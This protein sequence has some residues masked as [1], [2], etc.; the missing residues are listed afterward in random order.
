MTTNQEV[1]ERSRQKLP[2]GV[3]SP[4]RAF[5]SVGGTPPVIRQ[6]KGSRITDVEGRE[7]IDYVGSWGPAILGH[8]HPRI[9]EAAGKAAALGS[10]FGAPTEL[11]LAMAEAVIERVAS[12]EKVRMVSS[13]TEACMSAIR[14]ARGFTKRDR[15]VKFEGHYH[16]HAD[17]LL[18]SAGSGVA[19]LGI[20]G[21]PGVPEGAVKDTLTLPWNDAE[22][23]EALFE[24]SGGTI[25]AVIFEPVPGNMGLIPPLPGYLETLRRV[26]RAQGTLLICDEVMTGFR[27]HRGGAQ[28]LYPIEP[29]LSTFGKVIGGGYPVGAYGGRRDIMDHLA[30]VGPV[31]QAGTLSGNPVA[32]AA[33]LATLEELDRI[34]AY[35]ALEKRS[36]ALVDGL[37]A[38]TRA[39]GLPLSYARIGSMWTTFFRPEPPKDFR[40]AKDA[41]VPRFKKYFHSMLEQGIYLAASAF[42]AG[43]V[44]LAHSETDVERTVEAHAKAL[45]VAFR[46]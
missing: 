9:V 38:E 17:C 7:Y 4:V 26:T 30:P 16:G 31:Y 39:R 27:L 12:V 8:A 20:P 13:G 21:C 2:G 42:E 34:D 32:M 10:S 6:G 5:G 14:L 35:P 37:E 45:E 36:K 41:D 3:N 1:F 24:K 15:I 25:A 40:Q 18:A 43:F 22:A 33:G 11:E 23:F 28:A 44:S 29:D 46:G 19:T